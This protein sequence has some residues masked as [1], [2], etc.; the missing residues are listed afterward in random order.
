MILNNSPVI[1]VDGEMAERVYSDGEL[2]WG[3]PKGYKRCKYLE[4][5][6]KQ[7]IDT[8]VILDSKTY[9]YIKYVFLKQVTSG[10]F[11]AR[12]QPLANAYNSLYYSGDWKLYVTARKGTSG[13]LNQGYRITG[14]PIAAEIE[15]K[16]PVC[17]ANYN[18]EK[19]EYKMNDIAFS[20]EHTAM[21]FS[22][23][24][25]GTVY[26]PA[27]IKLEKAIF[28]E[29]IFIPSLDNS[30]LPCL[31][32][33]KTKQAFYNLG[34]GDFGYELMDGTYVDPI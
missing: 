21:L 13:A 10:I 15:F 9:S 1:Y 31:F 23:N 16:Y 20:C 34:T 8:G 2:V 11:G 24:N 7:Y 28:G 12:S 29:H 25:G 18:G 17:T 30:G 26:T 5:N 6:G 19:M 22:F 33:L 32:D 27:I 4:S 3:L 14:V